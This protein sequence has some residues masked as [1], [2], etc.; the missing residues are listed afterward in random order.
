MPAADSVPELCR[1][2]RASL[3]GTAEEID[4]ARD[5]SR[6]GGH[7]CSS[8]RCSLSGSDCSVRMTMGDCPPC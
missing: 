3:P 7:L 5:G 8:A 1:Y 4:S 2:Q 6:V